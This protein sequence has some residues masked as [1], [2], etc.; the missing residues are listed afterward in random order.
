MSPIE[1]KSALV[2]V[3]AWRRIHDKPLPELMK[4]PLTVACMRHT[5]TMG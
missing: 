2:Q 1:N 5:G 4:T 3:V